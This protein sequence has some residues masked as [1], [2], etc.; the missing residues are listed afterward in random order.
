MKIVSKNYSFTGNNEP[1]YLVYLQAED[2]T[3]AETYDVIGYKN[4]VNKE[5][6]LLDRYPSATI[7][8]VDYR[9]YQAENGILSEGY[10]LILCIYYDLMMET[11]SNE[12]YSQIT[13]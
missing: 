4:L 9:T 5:I 8:H 1:K 10:P 11:I 13:I 7:L 3:N 6:E 12:R 2:G